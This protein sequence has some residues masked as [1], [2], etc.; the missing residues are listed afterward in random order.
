ME[1]SWYEKDNPGEGGGRMPPVTL[2]YYLPA[3]EEE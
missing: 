3:K 2:V 1:A